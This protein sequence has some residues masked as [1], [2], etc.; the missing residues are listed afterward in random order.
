[1]REEI[2]KAQAEMKQN[3]DNPQKIA[4]IQKRVM[5]LNM[6]LMSQSFKPMLFTI[7]P[8]IAIFA[9]LGKVYGGMIV[10]PLF[11]WEGH[12]GWIGTYIIF[13]MIFTTGCRKLLKVV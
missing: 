11:F 7:I 3:K 9:F 4:E 13:S 8:L 10:I 1:M 2:K 5:P 12:L 6:K